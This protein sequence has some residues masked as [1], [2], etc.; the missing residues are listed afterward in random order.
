MFSERKLI[1]LSLFTIIF[2]LIGL[3]L[4][5]IFVNPEFVEIDSIDK[6]LVGKV[7]STEGTISKITFI[8]KS[9]T[10]FLDIRGNEKT[11]TIIIFNSKENS[12][13]KGDVVEIIGEVANYKGNLELIAREVEKI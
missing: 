2:G 5:C 3:Y 12:F 11:L 7:I 1:K 10:M 8:E 13:K 9:K 4:I 6:N